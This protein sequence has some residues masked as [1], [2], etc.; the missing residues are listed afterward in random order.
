MEE[1]SGDY[2][3]SGRAGKTGRGELGVLGVLGKTHIT[4]TTYITYSFSPIPLTFPQNFIAGV[5]RIE[6]IAIFAG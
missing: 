3:R 2:G 6:K 1:E 5:A 4:Y